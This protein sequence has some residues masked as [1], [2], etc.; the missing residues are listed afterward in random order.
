MN[1]EPVEDT[2]ES[3]QEAA[4]KSDDTNTNMPSVSEKG[5]QNAL[6]TASKMR[7]P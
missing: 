5:S 6:S 7:A 1:A 4:K 2:V 3:Y